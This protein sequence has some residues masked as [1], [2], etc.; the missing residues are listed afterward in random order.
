MG[1]LS[2]L[3]RLA[4]RLA[5]NKIVSGAVLG[6]ANVATGGVSGKVV[7]AAKSIGAKVKGNRLLKEQSKSVAAAIAKLDALP[8][9]AVRVTPGAHTLPGVPSDAELR[10]SPAP[11]RGKAKGRTKTSKLPRNPDFDREHKKAKAAKRKA[12][13]P[14]EKRV[15][16]K[17]K[18]PTGGLDMKALSKSWRAA[19]KPGTWREWLAK[20]G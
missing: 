14:N 5:K 1:F 20:K 10:R 13:T 4:K 3:G 19:G 7:S 11:P 6:L 8:K 16:S 9:L 18:A 12:G 2:G 15:K 17:R